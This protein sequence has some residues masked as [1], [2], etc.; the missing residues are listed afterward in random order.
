MVEVVSERV[1]QGLQGPREGGSPPDK[2]GPKQVLD[3]NGGSY[4]KSMQALWSPIFWGVPPL[5]F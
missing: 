5:P 1:S 3:P 2:D 4:L